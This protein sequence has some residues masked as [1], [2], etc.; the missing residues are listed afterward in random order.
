MV[1]L[2]TFFL[3]VVY[4][5]SALMR[6]REVYINKGKTLG[7]KV[8][9]LS[10]YACLPVC[11]SVCLS[12]C[13]SVSL[14]VC[15]SVCLCFS[16][17]LPACLFIYLSVCLSLSLHLSACLP[18]HLFPIFSFTLLSSPPAPSLLSCLALTSHIFSYFS[19]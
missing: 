6:I 3:T 16:V 12:V 4:A 5:Q 1:E 11:L 2:V 19:M 7:E 14:P 17:G 9:L 18:A 15:L 8:C 13:Q 10:V